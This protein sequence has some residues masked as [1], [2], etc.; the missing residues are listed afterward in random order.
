[1]L[2]MLMERKGKVVENKQVAYEIGL[3]SPNQNKENED[4]ADDIKHIK[5]KV[6]KILEK[7]GMTKKE[8]DTMI[9]SRRNIGY[10]LQD[11]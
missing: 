9:G 8:I 1:M 11:N 2:K 5:R 10:I 3:A 4:F 6:V 7:A